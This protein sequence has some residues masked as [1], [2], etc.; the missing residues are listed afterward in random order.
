MFG[1]PRAV[2]VLSL[3]SL[4]NDM[5][6]EMVVPLIPVLL[7]AVLSAGPVALG[8]V[9][10]VAD[11]VASMLKLWSGRHSDQMGGRRKGLALSGY[12]ISNLVRPAIALAGSWPVLLVLRSLDRVGKGLRDAPRDALV[13][14]YTPGHIRGLAFGVHRAFDNTG[15]VAGSL[16]AAFALWQGVS[17]LH[18]IELSALPGLLAVTLVGFGVSS[19]PPA[20]HPLPAPPAALRWKHL[21]VSLRR[22]LWLLMV[23]TFARGSETFLVLRGHELGMTPTSLLLLWALM[24]FSKALTSIRGGR[25]A[26][27]WGKLPVIR[28]AWF[29][30]GLGFLSLSM[31]SSVQDLWLVTALYG[32]LAGFS[33]GPERALVGEG[34]AID[35]RGS[36]YGWYHLITGLAAVP[37]GA[38][39]GLVWQQF[40]AGAAFGYAGGLALC[41][42]ALS[43]WLLKPDQ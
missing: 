26:D 30:Y 2:L 16:I 27:R 41:V 36:A 29:A 19:P 43:W 32:V 8:L 12:M 15:A 25:L 31:I 39:F 1:L 34:I 7:A 14:D 24:S 5:A 40:G 38:L 28:L 35:N 4:F 37:G 6:S 3:V 10:G 21:P 9:E 11:A 17:L 18:V 33:E 22:Y 13:A 20:E 42:S 23:F